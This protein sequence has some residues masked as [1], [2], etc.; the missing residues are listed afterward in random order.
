MSTEEQKPVV[1]EEV[2]EEKVTEVKPEET[3]KK[4]MG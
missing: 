1:A 2:K 3:Q 4:S